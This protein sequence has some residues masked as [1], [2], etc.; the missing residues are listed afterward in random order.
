V[1]VG[2]VTAV[3]NAGKNPAA[4]N[5]ARLTAA[6]HDPPKGVRI[7]ATASASIASGSALA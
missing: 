5:V 3:P 4:C 6:I 1:I 2:S 7:I